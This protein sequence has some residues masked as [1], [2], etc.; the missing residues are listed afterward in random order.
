MA[1]L[2]PEE[3]AARKTPEAR[4]ARQLARAERRAAAESAPEPKG[5]A[6]VPMSK[7]AA[8]A[9]LGSAAGR[10]GQ[11]EKQAKKLDTMRKLAELSPEE[12][13]AWSAK[14]DA[15]RAARKARR[16]QAPSGAEQPA[17]D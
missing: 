12:R 9:K 4:A 3:Q 6:A 10:K 17:Q 8:A 5:N 13:R 7:A 2:S 14:T 11:K 16:N 15:T 1:E